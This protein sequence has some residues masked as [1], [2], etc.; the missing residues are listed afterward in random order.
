MDDQ[1]SLYYLSPTS[2]HQ[3]I[4][5][6]KHSKLRELRSG[7]TY[8]SSD[9]FFPEFM[10]M[11]ADRFLVFN[12]DLDLYAIYDA[13]SGQTTSLTLRR[14]CDRDCVRVSQ[15]GRYIRYYVR[16]DDPYYVR[17]STYRLFTYP[18]PQTLPYQLYEYD[19]V[20]QTERLLFEQEV[21]DVIDEQPVKSTG[22]CTPDQHGDRW[23]CTLYIDDD[24]T[25]NSM[26]DRKFIVHTNGQIEHVNPTW[27]LRVLDQQWYFLDLDSS[28]LG[29]SDCTIN[30]YPNGSQEQTFAFKVPESEMFLSSFDVQL[31]SEDHLLTSPIFE[32]VYAISRSGELTKLG[33]SDCCSDPISSDFYDPRTGFMIVIDRDN[34]QSSIWDTRSFKKVATFPAGYPGAHHAFQDRAVVLLTLEPFFNI[35]SMYSLI[36]ERAYI[37]NLE[38]RRGFLDA[39]PGG[40]LLVDWGS[41]FEHA[42]MYRAEDDGIYTWT[43]D[44]GE[45]L[46]I[47]GAINIPDSW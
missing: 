32:P 7:T 24:E 19:T 26:A 34:L 27:Q 42:I 18:I 12:T 10:R 36:D 22:G 3:V 8:L 29:C 16:G 25:P 40:A 31:L 35:Y 47:E 4:E 9:Y 30:V 14:W 6:V 13:A 15:D 33:F 37:F 5:F 28:P 46:L 20:T 11:D 17:L 45:T 21:V 23:Y 39:I 1:W 43:P 44:V 2:A 38:E 41:D